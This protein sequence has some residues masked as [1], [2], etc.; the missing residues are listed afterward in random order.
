MDALFVA[1]TIVFF[2]LCGLYV[3]ACDRMSRGNAA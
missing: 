1:L 2:V 3:A